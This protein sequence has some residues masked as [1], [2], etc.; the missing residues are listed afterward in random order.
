[1]KADKIEQMTEDIDDPEVVWLRVKSD[2]ET[3]RKFKALCALRGV[4]M[5]DHLN[6]VVRA[7]INQSQ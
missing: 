1:M 7:Y 5:Q 3:V 2:I 4:S 6:D